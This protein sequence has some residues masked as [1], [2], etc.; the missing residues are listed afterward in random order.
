MRTLMS[1]AP[2]IKLHELKE[3]LHK[4]TT[5]Q[6]EP[7]QSKAKSLIKE[8]K[9]RTE[10]T[11]DSS[12]KILDNSQNEMTKNNPKT[13]RFARNANKFSE[14]LIN[15]LKAV[16]VSEDVQYESIKNL[17]DELERTCANIDQLRRS[18]YPYI[19]PYFIFDRRRLDVFI[20]RLY[21][22]TKEVRQFLTS[23]YANV[24][25]FDEANLDAEKLLQ[26]LHEMKQNQESL[27]Q[28]EVRLQDLESRISE[29]KDKLTE[30]R[31]R[32]ELSE[33]V[34]LDHEADEMR[35]QVKHGLRYLQKP[36]YKL[37]S[38]SR[39]SEIAIPP[40][41]L[42]KVEDY[43]TDPLAA[44]TK[45]DDGYPT[46]KSVLKKLDTAIAQGKLKLKS[47][48]L[49]KAQEQINAI[50]NQNALGQLQQRGCTV[51]TQRMQALSSDTV[52]ALQDESTRLQKHLEMLQKDYETCAAQAKILKS[53]QTKLNE[54]AEH[55]KKDL[56]GKILQLTRKN[57]Q[58][59][60]S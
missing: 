45:E 33:L 26:T 29:T 52:R 7:L 15:T 39:A 24:R 42:H 10:D 22:I 44:L 2:Q 41:E 57:V 58:I 60:T 1:Q 20:K 51:L 54:K 34:R 21:D 18:A 8:I 48:R 6:F 30:T 59:V 14:S 36:F 27:R 11:I 23:K 9:E 43:L 25:M 13:H 31:S 32:A 4:E 28:I 53:N 3:W 55:L 37:Q 40:D 5:S 19:S 17:C 38:L 56:E 35:A 47:T 12:E 50:L 46:L 49:R 16:N